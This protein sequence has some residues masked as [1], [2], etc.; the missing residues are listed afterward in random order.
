M[1]EENRFIYNASC[2]VTSV[3]RCVTEHLPQSPA[4]QCLL[5]AVWWSAV[6]H[7]T[8]LRA[9]LPLAAD[10]QL[11]G[12]A[13]LG[14]LQVLT[15]LSGYGEGTVDVKLTAQDLSVLHAEATRL[16]A[17]RPLAD[18]PTARQKQ[19]AWS[20]PSLQLKTLL[21]AKK[22]FFISVIANSNSNSKLLQY[23]LS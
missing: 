21:K 8:P 11:T 13:T 2:A 3:E 16:T 23:R 14:T 17:L 1:E 7:R 10:L 4:S 9:N 20:G 5:I 18:I 19:S 15:A 6:T 12:T 22:H